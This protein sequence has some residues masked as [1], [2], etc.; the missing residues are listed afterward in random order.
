MEGGKSPSDDIYP[1][2]S[3]TDLLRNLHLTAKEGAVA[4]F[5]DDEDEGMEPVMTWALVGKVLT[6]S[7]LHIS[8]IRAAMKS[9]W[10][11]PHGLKLRSIGEK[12]VNLFVAEF[13]GQMDMDRAL[14]G[15]P[16]MVGKHAMI[17]QGYDKRLSASEIR[18]D[19]MEIWARIPN[20]PL[21]WMNDQ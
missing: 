2:P 12:T 4:E 15:S 16:W 13:G 18:F 19:K 1:N 7:V 3:V 17:L 20:L 9:A 10:G 6:L 5:S 8:T 11:N 14:V 21:G